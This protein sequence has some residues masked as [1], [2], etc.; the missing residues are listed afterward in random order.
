MA[1]TIAKCIGIDLNRRKVETRLGHRAS[2]AQANTY[3]TFTTCYVSKDGSGY[4]EVTRDGK[5]LHRFEFGPEG[6]EGEAKP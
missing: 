4:V 3:R 1:A 6:P 2:E 5:T